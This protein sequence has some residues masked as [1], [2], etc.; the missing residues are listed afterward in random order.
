[1]SFGLGYYGASNETSAELDYDGHPPRMSETTRQQ[2]VEAIANDYPEIK[3]MGDRD[4]KAVV[5]LVVNEHDQ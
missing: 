1:M 4:Q 5:K 2:I 3:N